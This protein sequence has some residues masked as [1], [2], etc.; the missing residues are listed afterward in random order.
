[1]EL[2]HFTACA[3]DHD[4]RLDRVIRRFLPEYSLS[5]LY[6]L[7]RQGKI[8]LNGSKTGPAARV[9]CA[10]DIGID[11]YILTGADCLQSSKPLH[12]GPP[13][14]QN[15]SA[16]PVVVYQNA[17]LLFINKAA[18]TTVQGPG[19]IAEQVAALAGSA[20]SLSFRS[21]PLHRLDR[22]T[23][24]LVC[25]SASLRGAR[26]FSQAIAEH[27]LEKYYLGIAEGL[28]EQEAKWQDASEDGK[29]S[30]TMVLPLANNG[31]H[32]AAARSLVLYRLITGRKHQIRYQSALHGLP[33]LGDRQYNPSS[34]ERTYFLHAWQ[35][36]FPDKPEFPLPD[37]LTAPLPEAFRAKIV[38]EFGKDMLAHIEAGDVYWKENEE[39]Q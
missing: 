13:V 31:R 28:L 39:H 2:I 1:M 4:R 23:T 32:G 24:G 7:M 18:G 29:D 20:P 11:S 37:R 8:R 19:S 17:D 12:S 26:W 10:D 15:G 5:L 38:E 9:R 21:G 33:L 6:R 25:F 3:D 14:A 16:E 27:R 34:P 30:L 35:L 22:D 36:F